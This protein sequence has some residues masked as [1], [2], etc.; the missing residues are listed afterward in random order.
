VRDGLDVFNVIPKTD[1]CGSD[2]ARNEGWLLGGDARGNLDRATSVVD[3]SR[4][5]EPTITESGG[6]NVEDGEECCYTSFCFQKKKSLQRDE[7]DVG[8]IGTLE[9]FG[10]RWLSLDSQE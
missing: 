3:L 8:S 5:E 2:S 9:G 7:V 4:G 6:G 10:R 1:G